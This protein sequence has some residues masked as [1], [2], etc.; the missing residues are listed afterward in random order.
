LGRIL[1][2]T[3]NDWVGYIQSDLGW[4]DNDIMISGSARVCR[5]PTPTG[6]SIELNLE[7]LNCLTVFVSVFHKFHQ[8]KKVKFCAHTRVWVGIWNYLE[9]A[10]SLGLPGSVLW[11]ATTFLI[12]HFH[13]RGIRTVPYRRPS[14]ADGRGPPASGPVGNGPTSRPGRTTLTWARADLGHV[15]KVELWPG[16]NCWFMFSLSAASVL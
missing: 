1:V 3:Q 6:C 15:G 12:S 13:R 2:F 16:P 9:C 4:A 7:I 5:V 10:I 8:K 14:W 11:R